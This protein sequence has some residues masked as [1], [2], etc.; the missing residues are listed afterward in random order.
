MKTVIFSLG[1]SLIVPKG[2]IDTKFLKEFRQFILNLLSK[3]YRV[4]LIAGGGGT[5][6]YYNEGAKS[7]TTVKNKDLDLIGIA[8]TK[9]NAELIRSIFSDYAYP[10]VIANPYT[11][12][13][14]NKKV[15]VASGW[16]PG[17]S[18]D[19]DAVIWAENLKGELVINLSNIDFVYD[20]DPRKYSDAKPIKEISWTDFRKIVGNKWLPGMSW[21]FDPIASRLAQQL[22]LKV[23]V[24]NGQNLKNLQD[25]LM[26]RNF[27]GT[28]IG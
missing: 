4:V 20:K 15:I 17:F 25:C 18:S 22:E 24:A 3:K 1:G 9:L 11:K 14:T 28:T 10:E 5:C 16:K 19:K 23:V 13:K 7:V 6:R 26:G 2:I 27:K 12:I 8:A 21:P